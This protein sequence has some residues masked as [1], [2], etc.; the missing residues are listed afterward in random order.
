MEK[1]VRNFRALIKVIL[2]IP[3]I[4]GYLFTCSL[5][6][7]F[8]R[9]PIRQRHLYARTVTWFSQRALWFINVELSVKNMPPVGQP[10]LLVGNH[11]GIMDILLL[12][13]IRHCLFITSVEMK[14]TPLLGTLCE[15]GGCLFV[16]RRNRANINKEILHI[17]EA[18]KQ[19]FNIVLYP[20]GTSS[21]GER[22]LPFKK[23]MMT[24]AAGTGVPI[25]PM[26]LNFTEVN[27]E[28]MSGKWRNHVF[29]YGDQAF[30]PAMWKAMS[31]RSI[32]A[33]IEFLEPIFCHSEEER[34]E[35]AVKAHHQ[36]EQKFVK[37]PLAPGEVSDFVPPEHF[38]KPQPGST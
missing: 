33:E 20:E 6:K 18:L 15:M 9:N 14:N 1:I 27:G 5:W 16:E 38:S 24:A 12:A 28:K 31:L 11:L 36:I 35:I 7:I 4:V 10:F 2:W 13:S 26:V 32:K 19:G 37:V 23:T 21:N 22:M 17:R 25:L 34:R 8:V 3:V 29:W 30:P